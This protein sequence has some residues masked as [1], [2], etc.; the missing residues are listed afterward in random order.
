MSSSLRRGESEAAP[1][2]MPYHPVPLGLS[3]NLEVRQGPVCQSIHTIEYDLA[4]SA[5]APRRRAGEEDSGQ[6]STVDPVSAGRLAVRF[7]RGVY[8]ADGGSRERVD[9]RVAF[10]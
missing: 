4:S 8:S 9:E 1:G 2:H 10:G 5:E 3:D 7:V 6:P